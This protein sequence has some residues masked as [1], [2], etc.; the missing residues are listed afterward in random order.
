MHRSSSLITFSILRVASGSA[1]VVIVIDSIASI[2]EGVMR[3]HWQK[4]KLAISLVDVVLGRQ[5]V[6]FQPASSPATFFCEL[7]FW[8]PMMTLLILLPILL[9]QIPIRV[10]VLALPSPRE[11]T[12]HFETWKESLAHAIYYGMLYWSTE[13]VLRVAKDIIFFHRLLKHHINTEVTS[14]IY[15]V[16]D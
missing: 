15:S 9:R 14:S 8:A 5:T 1:F 2:L 10:R 13:V 6:W 4:S 11:V 3:P 16:V 12:F 7:K